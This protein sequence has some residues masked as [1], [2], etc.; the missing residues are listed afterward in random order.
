M[1]T[2]TI[3]SNLTKKKFKGLDKIGKFNYNSTHWRKTRKAKYNANPICEKCKVNPTHTI[4]HIIP[5]SQGGDP[6]LWDNLMSLCKGCNAR[7]TAK[8]QYDKNE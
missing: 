6:Y 4:D 7:K 3:I 2:E 5:I 8:Q 1:P